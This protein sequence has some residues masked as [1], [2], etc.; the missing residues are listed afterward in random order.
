MA[1]VKRYVGV[2]DDPENKVIVFGPC[3]WDGE[4]EFDPGAGVDMMLEAE[5]LEDGYTYPPQEVVT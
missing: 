1:E 3:L 4:T 5:A 2:S